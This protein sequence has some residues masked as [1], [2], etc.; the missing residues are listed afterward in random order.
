VTWLL[1]TPRRALAAAGCALLIVGVG[2]T[3]GVSWMAYQHQMSTYQ[4]QLEAEQAA[5]TGG[6]A[7]MVP[8][9]TPAS[10]AAYTAVRGFT[11]AWLNA[12]AQ[13]DQ[14]A[15][16]ESMRPYATAELLARIGPDRKNLPAGV[17]A[18]VNGPVGPDRADLQVTLTTKD[19]FTETVIRTGDG[20]WLVAD[21]RLVEP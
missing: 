2:I 20:Q 8:A 13:P 12:A 5:A 15:W 11:G 17:L 9:G 16:V 18:A 3:F 19:V 10:A 21:I 1:W 6:A 7:G 4:D 14:G